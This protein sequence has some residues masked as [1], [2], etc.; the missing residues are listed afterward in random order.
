M[1]ETLDTCAAV[2]AS[3]AYHLHRDNDYCRHYHRNH[4]HLGHQ[5]P[6]SISE[7]ASHGLS[8]ACRLPSHLQPEPSK[9]LLL[10]L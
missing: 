6:S 8:L 9:L 4:H 2:Q 10:S 1:A 5:H 7:A 3:E